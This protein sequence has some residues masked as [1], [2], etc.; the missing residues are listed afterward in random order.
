MLCGESRDCWR[1]LDASGKT[2]DL[3]RREQYSQ[4][5]QKEG[6]DE[7]LGVRFAS[8][9]TPLDVAPRG[10]AFMDVK[11]ASA[12]PYSGE[13]T[14]TSVRSIEFAVQTPACGGRQR[15]DLV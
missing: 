7:P 15:Q 10:G 9:A 8:A 4:M 3:R 6:A 5:Y 13:C 1:E 14:L 12:S 11:Y 2:L